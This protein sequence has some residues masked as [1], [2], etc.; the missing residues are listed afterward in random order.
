MKNENTQ[1]V[2]NETPE[3]DKKWKPCGVVL[4]KKTGAFI[5]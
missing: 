2:K 1:K 5:F 4:R 3:K